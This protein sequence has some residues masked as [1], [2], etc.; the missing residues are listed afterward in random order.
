ME[1]LIPLFVILPLVSAFLIPVFGRFVKGFNKI[2]TLVVFL[3]LF[4]LS[5]YYLFAGGH[6]SFVYKIGG[7]E[8]VDG[9]PIA[10]YFLLDPLSL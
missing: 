7:W 9:I 2:I 4:I 6:A 5:L 1:K 10:I 3:A 8:P